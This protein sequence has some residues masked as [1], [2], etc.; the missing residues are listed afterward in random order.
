[1]CSASSRILV[2][3]NIRDEFIERFK[4][5]VGVTVRLG[6]PLD[7]AATMGPL[8][9]RNQQKKVLSY[10]DIGKQEGAELALGGSI[11]EGFD[12][13]SYVAPT[14]FSGVN[15]RMQIAKEEIFGPV[16]AVLTFSSIYEAVKNRQR[17][18]IRLS[19]GDLDLRCD[20][21]S[22]NGQRH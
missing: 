12:G 9:S 6:D 14:L 10:I 18:N 4:A 2:D 13:G 15:N 5:K 17:F 16:G 7:P 20:H 3:T 22:Q 11:P 8:V 21:C 19:G 1:M